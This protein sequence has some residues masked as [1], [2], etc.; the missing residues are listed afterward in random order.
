MK[1][2]AFLFVLTCFVAACGGD[3][4]AP[5]AAFLDAGAD[6]SRD[7]GGEDA[8]QDAGPFQPDPPEAPRPLEWPCPA[9]WTESAAS[10]TQICA[11]ASGPNDCPPGEARFIDSA[12]CAP[13]ATCPAAD[14]AEVPAGAIYVTPGGTGDGTR[15]SPTNL[16]SAIDEASGETFI[17]LGEGAYTAAFSVPG[18]VHLVGLCP[19]RTSLSPPAPAPQ[20]VLVVE[21]GRSV[22]ISGIRILAA[23]AIGL[24]TLGDLTAF[25]V[26]IDGAGGAG[27]FVGEEASFNGE[28]LAVRDTLPD[29][30]G[31]GGAGIISEG[32]V[33]GRNWVLRRNTGAGLW[34]DGGNV[35]L[36]RLVSTANT[37]VG[38]FDAGAGVRQQSGSLRLRE[39]DLRGAT[40]FA[41]YIDGGDAAISDLYVDELV[42]IPSPLKEVIRVHDASLVLERAFVRGSDWLLS[43]DDSPNLELRDA[44]LVN[45]EDSG[46]IYAQHVGLVAVESPVTIERA[47]FVGGTTGMLIQGPFD[48]SAPLPGEEPEPPPP[49]VPIAFHAE[50][51]SVVEVGAGVDRAYGVWFDEPIQASLERVRM[52]R[53]RGTALYSAGPARIRD[54]RV[55]EMLP[56][57]DTFGTAVVFTRD[58]RDTAESSIERGHFEGLFH[59]GVNLNGRDTQ[60]DHV[61]VEGTRRKPCTEEPCSLNPG[62]TAIAAVFDARIRAQYL[63]VEDADLCGLQFAFDAMVTLRD[64]RI[65]G[66]AIGACVQVE[67][68]D[69]DAITD[70]VRYEDNGTNIE[71]TS[72][73]VPDAPPP[74]DL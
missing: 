46:F 24:A 23:G 51:L 44:L 42:S 74:P 14:F 57:R 40:N 32:E 12:E 19:S 7:A 66:A 65:A 64:S 3:D 17:A 41:V 29:S 59:V 20:A 26:S 10:G 16:R 33:R 34:L 45:T 61:H 11:P 43:A 67:G 1:R 4:D 21:G 6:A 18:G 2:G 30:A 48:F 73:D 28:N 63:R 71:T 56:A 72:F 69:L 31:L 5:D 37:P 55:E 36:S 50:D 22:H 62:G 8:P 15:A 54:I 39:A 27:V 68:Y 60:L 53:I 35:E 70:G 13:V 9:G 38:M 25:D 49:L 47:A 58:E 52:E